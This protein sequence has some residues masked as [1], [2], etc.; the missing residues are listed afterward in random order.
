MIEAFLT[1]PLGGGSIVERAAGHEGPAA[2]LSLC[3]VR[4]RATAH[5]CG[6]VCA[7]LCKGMDLC[8]CMC[9]FSAS[10]VPE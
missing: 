9:M 6:R 3:C 7:C 2:P 1:G 5:V 10:K 4:A 8:V